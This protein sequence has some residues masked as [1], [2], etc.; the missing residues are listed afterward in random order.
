MYDCIDGGKCNLNSAVNDIACVEHEI[1]RATN[2]ASMEQ[3]MRNKFEFVSK[4][5]KTYSHAQIDFD[6][7]DAQANVVIRFE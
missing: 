4:K 3:L 1:G 6:E 5:Q 2:R 7:N